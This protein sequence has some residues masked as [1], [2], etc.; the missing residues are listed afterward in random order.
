MR[1]T[2]VKLIAISLSVLFA[3]LLGE[4]ASR[5]LFYSKKYPKI[6]RNQGIERKVKVDK[7]KEKG[8]LRVAFLGDSYTYGFGIKVKDNFTEVTQRKLTKELTGRKVQCLNFGRKGANTEKELEILKEKILPYD[9]DVLVMGF[10]LNDFSDNQRQGRVNKLYAKD[11][12]KYR[13]FLKLEKASKL[14]YYIDQF[15]FGAFGKTGQIQIDELTSLYDPQKNPRYGDLYGM[16]EEI[17]VE[18]SS[19]KG[20]MLFFPHFIKDES[21]LPFYQNAKKMVEEVCKKHGVSFIEIL[22]HL[23]HKP[24]YKWWLHPADHHPNVE[25]HGIIADILTQKILQGQQTS[26]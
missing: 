18:M 3:L 4:I 10:V 26:N 25:A 13:P 15:I 21:S 11:R 16:L 9:P 8:M 24:F 7:V 17:V 1:K 2:V 23:Q 14:F 6:I 20:V 22:P 5:I 19:R 12:K